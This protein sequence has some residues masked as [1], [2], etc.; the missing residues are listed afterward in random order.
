[1]T[2][3]SAHNT[4]ITIPGFLDIYPCL[5]LSHLDMK[6][7]KSSFKCQ[8]NV[9]IVQTTL[10]D[11]YNKLLNRHLLIANL[12]ILAWTILGKNVFMR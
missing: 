10:F 8:F 2:S 4:S 6:T 5:F 9:D 1:M 3:V 11:K 12:T 7:E